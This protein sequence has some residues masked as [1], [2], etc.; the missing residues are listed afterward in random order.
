MVA[1]LSAV[2]SS[3]LKP[4][5]LYGDDGD[6]DPID[7]SLPDDIDVPG[8]EREGRV[9]RDSSDDDEEDDDDRFTRLRSR[10]SS[11]EGVSSGDFFNL[12][13]N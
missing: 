3:A 1:G 11:R 4:K 2:D 6:D 13:I 5:R 12:L 9:E 10:P 8:E 7:P